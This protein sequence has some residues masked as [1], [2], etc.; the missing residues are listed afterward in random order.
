ME[1]KTVSL[2]ADVFSILSS[3][4]S[5]VGVSFSRISYWWVFYKTKK[6]NKIPLK[7]S[8]MRFFY[9]NTGNIIICYV[10][11]KCHSKLYNISCLVL[12]W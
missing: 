4:I 12:F 1:N 7:I 5:M 11:L 3:I 6:W 8:E 2:I 9:K 10:F